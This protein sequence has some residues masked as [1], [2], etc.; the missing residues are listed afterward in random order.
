EMTQPAQA[1]MI[2]YWNGPAGARWLANEAEL[3]RAIAP[4]G[5][6]ALA[7]A[8]A[9]PGE[10][11]VDVGCGCGRTT[12]ALARAVGAS[13]RVLGVDVAAAMIARARE[14]GRAAGVENA[15]WIE[16]DASVHRFVSENDLLFSRFGVMFFADPTAA[17]ANLRRALRAG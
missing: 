14:E 5:A 4:F 6:A 3:D 16:A 9:A 13:G 10:R 12:L 2:A 11:V 17:F 8:K 15:A 1:E 7:A